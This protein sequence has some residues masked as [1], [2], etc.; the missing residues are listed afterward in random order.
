[1]AFEARNPATGELLGTRPELRD[2]VRSSFWGD[3]IR[4]QANCGDVQQCF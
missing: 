4:H 3:T 1:M 2:S